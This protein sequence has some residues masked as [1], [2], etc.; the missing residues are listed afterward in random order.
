MGMPY[1]HFIISV[2][3]CYCFWFLS[4][5]ARRWTEAFSV[6]L[7]LKY[8]CL[9]VIFDLIAQTCAN[10][11]SSGKKSK[12]RTTVCVAQRNSITGWT[13][14][15]TYF[16]T[17]FVHTMTGDCECSKFSLT[18]STVWTH[19]QDPSCFCNRSRRMQDRSFSDWVTKKMYG[20][21][22]MIHIHAV[23]VIRNSL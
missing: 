20:F 1:H 13:C 18:C 17:W 23:W 2:G 15:N 12:I 19:I 4:Y 21:V 22:N 3:L 6:L 11:W 9:E 5:C 8:Q 10:P 14:S 7:P 16:R